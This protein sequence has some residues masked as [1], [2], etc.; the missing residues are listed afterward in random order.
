MPTKKV[1]S[2][3]AMPKKAYPR[4][5]GKRNAV[6]ETPD[7]VDRVVPKRVARREEPEEVVPAKVKFVPEASSQSEKLQKVLAR[8][9][10]G[11]RR[12]LETWIAQ[13]RVSV[14]G[15]I[16]G[17]G[18][19]VSEG[20]K[21]RADGILLDWRPEADQ[22]HRII[23]Y[24]KPEG[25]VCSRSDPEGRPSVFEHLP[26]LS[27]G[28]WILVGRLDLNTSGLMLFTTDGELAH[29]LTHPSY[30]ME[31]EY[32]VRVLGEV[33]K[34][35]L[36]TLREGVELE[37]GK[38]A[39][40]M[41]REA[42]GTGAN[43]W[44]HVILKEGRNREVRRLWESQGVKVS[45]LIR[46]RFGAIPLDRYLKKGRWNDLEETLAQ[47]LYQAV[48]LR[49]HSR[50]KKFAVRKK[51]VIKSPRVTKDA[52]AKKKPAAAARKIKRPARPS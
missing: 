44:Y 35:V 22:Q 16:V 4:P 50:L 6:W 48:D 32:A 25:E 42:G 2:K 15:K 5:A 52:G 46:V 19:R 47:Q 28:R 26:S 9:G 33:P 43:H 11:S 39:F 37:D 24:H 18:E 10:L 17:L 40:T 29:R 20:D 36:T 31:R 21:I 41:I 27:K 13:G 34:E 45:R 12:E 7:A 38:A 51:V 49:F 1:S 3:K 23:C 14:N 30:E 8:V